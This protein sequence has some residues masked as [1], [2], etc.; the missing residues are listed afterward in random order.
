MG[1][2]PL[3]LLLCANT[4]H[5]FVRSSDLR[6]YSDYSH[7]HFFGGERLMSVSL[8]QMKSSFLPARRG[9][10]CVRSSHSEG[11]WGILTDAGG[12]SGG[13]ESLKLISHGELSH[14]VSMS[15]SAMPL[16]KKVCST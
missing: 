12:C 9:E 3:N 14:A 16:T 11:A 10:F 6:L 13:K 5:M 15:T 1:V 8:M 4:F 2:I 7:C